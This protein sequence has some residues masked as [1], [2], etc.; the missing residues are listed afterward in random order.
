MD[1]LQCPNE[2][3]MKKKK[4][5]LPNKEEVI[6]IIGNISDEYYTTIQSTFLFIAP[7]GIVYFSFQIIYV[8][9]FNFIENNK[10]MV[11]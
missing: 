2:S 1:H 10:T 5:K 8:C 4:L 3:A 9:I 11:W 6:A 7:F